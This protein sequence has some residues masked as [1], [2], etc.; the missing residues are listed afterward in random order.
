MEASSQMRLWGP[1]RSSW[2]PAVVDANTSYQRVDALTACDQGAVAA[3]R[4]RREGSH[5]REE[6]WN[7]FL[8]SPLEFVRYVDEFESPWCEPTS[9][10]ATS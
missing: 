10:S 9:T 5:C 2:F 1:T 7:K 4:A 3:G 8:L 6:V